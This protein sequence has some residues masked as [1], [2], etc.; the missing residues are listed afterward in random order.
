MICLLR[1]RPALAARKTPRLEWLEGRQLLSTTELPPGIT[2]VQVES[3][4]SSSQELVISFDQSAVDGINSELADFF[5]PGIDFS[6]LI[7]NLD[8]NDDFDLTGPAGTI[9]SFN[10]PPQA[11]SVS[12]TT[13][14]TNV[15]IPI[16][17]S[18]PVGT[19]HVGLS[20]GT[21][22]DFLFSMLDSQPTNTFWSSLASA[23]EPV[24]IDQFTVQPQFGPTLRNATPMGPVSTAP[25][26]VWGSLDPGKIPS[27]VDLYEFTLSPGQLWEVGVAISTQHLNRSLPTTLTLFNS[28][29]DVIAESNSG[30]GLPNDPGDPYLFAGVTPTLGSDTYYI[31][32]SAYGNT[33][34]GSTGFNPVTGIP[35]S[36]GTTEPAGQFELSVAALPHDQPTQLENFSLGHEDSLSASP[37]SLTLTFSA[38]I[39]LNT[40]FVPDHQET[41]LEV[42]DSSG[43]QWPI[44]AESYQV[45]N[46]QLTLVFDQPL[47]DGNY[48]LIVPQ[49]GGLTDLAGAPVVAPDEPAGVLASWSVGPPPGPTPPNDLGVLWPGKAGVIWP[50]SSDSF[51]GT[52]SLAPGQAISYRW[53]VLV[54]G[55]Y[56]VQTETTG[57]SLAVENSSGASTTVLD[58]ESNGYLNN[59]VMILSAGVYELKFINVGSQRASLDWLLRIETLDWD[60]ILDNGVSQSSALSLMTFVPAPAESVTATGLF[61]VPPSAVGAVFNDTA[62]PVPSNLLIT[63]NS[64]LAGQPTWNGQ[65]VGLLTETGDAGGAGQAL[66]PQF[67][68]LSSSEGDVI[69]DA[70]GMVPSQSN[71]LVR[72]DGPVEPAPRAARPERDHEPATSHADTRAIAQ[73]EWVMRIGSLVQDWLKTSPSDRPP[74]LAMSSPVPPLAVIS[75][76]TNRFLRVPESAWRHR[77]LTSAQRSRLGAAAGL[78]TIGTI[79]YRLRQPVRKWWRQNTQIVGPGKL[80]RPRALPGPH[81]VLRASRMKTHVRTR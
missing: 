9:F 39:D 3:S 8:F 57:S 42:V 10:Q 32:V 14:Q 29:G 75:G 33:P 69:D 73:A 41:A 47:P 48:Q 1:L 31:G 72:N 45:T 61:S 58:Y 62:G 15:I 28:S 49:T 46:A 37:T 50:T 34:Y 59:Y 51:S 55:I 43:E 24:T 25:Q 20:A 66:L 63:L 18:L 6:Y 74:Q 56:D 26:N 7:N 65:T 17:G 77:L 53:A 68:T 12:S 21:D 19:Y 52:T 80:H 22:L 5:G 16:T 40:L 4:G 64:P 2:S 70:G 79:A 71:N 54:P 11:I 36:Q 23:A 76:Q 67:A 78:I 38:P 13:A 30:S 81:P 35:G 44:T 27:A 60:K